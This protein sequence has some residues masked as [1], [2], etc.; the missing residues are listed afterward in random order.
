M[1]FNINTVSYQGLPNHMMLGM[2]KWCFMMEQKQDSHYRAINYV[3]RLMDNVNLSN[4]C[5]F[6][7]YMF[8]VFIMSNG[9]EWLKHDGVS[10]NA[11]WVIKV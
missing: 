3:H 4:L 10:R 2:I 6:V 7:N 9:I 5:L 1:K 11:V 8:K